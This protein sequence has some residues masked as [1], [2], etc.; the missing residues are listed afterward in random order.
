MPSINGIAIDFGTTNSCV[1]VFQDGR[2][3]IIANDQG[4]RT[5]P[6]YVTF[7][8]T[9]RLVGESAKKRGPNTI[10]DIKRLLG[11]KF[12][13][14]IAT[15]QADMQR[16]PFTVVEENNRPMIEMELGL[17]KTKRFAPEEISSMILTKMKETAEAYL[18]F[19]VTDAV[20]TV[21]AYFND[22]QRRAIKDAGVIAG[23]NVIRVISDS[24]AAAITYGLERQRE[25]SMEGEWK[26][27]IFNVGGGNCDVSILNMEA[28]ILE[29]MS[30]AGDTHLGEGWWT[31]LSMNSDACT[32]RTSRKV[33]EL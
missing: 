19:E 31:T 18:G 23:L 24:T 16:W 13:D 32:R 10:F 14:P 29:V 33:S 21:P 6:S 3:E 5:T 30:T 8:D 2:V 20:V 15:V 22:S 9:Q 4:N 27:L 17:N 25:S 1:A 11:R 28:G 7:W 12:D 26:V